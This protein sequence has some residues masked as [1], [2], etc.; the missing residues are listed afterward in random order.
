MSTESSTELQRYHQFQKELLTQGRTDLSPEEVLRLWRAQQQ[1]YADTV[2][3]IREGLVDV[4]AGRT[5]PLEHFD[6]KFREKH[7]I[8]HDGGCITG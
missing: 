5:E 3:A 8:P 6:R 2:E 4:K 7:N 1:D